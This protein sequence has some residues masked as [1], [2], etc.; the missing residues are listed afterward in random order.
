MSQ[1]ITGIDHVVI[2]VHDLDRARSAYQRLGFVTSP[3]GVHSEHVGTHNH[4]IMLE[5]DYFEVLAVRTPTELNARWREA[6]ERRE[7]AHIVALQTPDAEAAAKELRARGV[8]VGDPVRFSRPVDTPAGPA[9]ARFVVAFI[10][11]DATPAATMFVCQHLTPE[12]VWL[13]ELKRH[14]NTAERIDSVTALVDDP[15]AVIGP[16]TALFGADRV[17]AADDAVEVATGGAP[18]RFVGAGALAR[19][20]PGV[21]LGAIEPPAIVGL[22]IKVRDL[23]ATRVCLDDAGIVPVAVDGGWCVPPAEACGVVLE[24]RA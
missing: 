8:A 9:E 21:D 16:Y 11:G 19:L 6:L 18:I 10:P 7:G 13:P 17:G 12:H 4:T 23:T 1:A 3:R 22:G 5:D 2:L 15:Q 14:P 20:Y 24:F